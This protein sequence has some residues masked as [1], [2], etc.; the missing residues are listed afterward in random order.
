M[1]SMKILLVEDEDWS[2]E[3]AIEVLTN[4]DPAAEIMVALYRDDALMQ[5]RDNDFDL[6]IC[7]LRLPPIANSA[8]VNEQHGL[9][10]HGLARELCPGT[11]LTFLTGYPVSRDTMDKLSLGD[12]DTLFGLPGEALVR[13]VQKDDMHALETL[14]SRYAGA[15][16][17][18]DSCCTVAGGELLDPLLARA[19]RIYALASGHD[20]AR[21]EFASG[22]SGASVGRVLLE[23]A[24]LP[25]ARVF[26]KVLPSAAARD[27]FDRCNRLVAN[28]I[29][30]GYFAPA[31]AP[32]HSGLRKMSALVSPLASASFRSLFDLARTDVTKA[33]EVISEL[34]R[35]TT[36]WFSSTVEEPVTLEDLRR[37]RIS[38]ERIQ[39][40]VDWDRFRL[41]ESVGVTM[42]MGIV[43]GDLHGENVLVD[44]VGRPVLIDFGDVG[45]GFA[46]TDPVTL[47]LSLIYHKDGPA[48][49][50][51]L[52]ASIN[53][54]D[55]LNVEVCYESS[56]LQPLAIECRAW[57]QE[58]ADLHSIAAFAYAH[59]MRQLKYPDVPHAVAVEVAAACGAF[60]EAPAG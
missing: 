5:I 28:R 53:W 16:Q 44:A 41:F 37:Q 1:G 24:I 55:W 19:V 32:I 15:L 57:A 17:N 34:R 2:V 13:L 43:H 23:S 30:I 38:D 52:G 40:L 14:V 21:V 20:S 48:R 7:D 9:A 31:L 29:P 42:T 8:D 4:A 51:D 46:P 47:E 36:D 58:V 27:E 3:Q 11:P 12:V 22:L 6:I 59:S 39:D 18:L 45:I 26:L 49:D 35:A 50:P 25:P 56:S 33:A 10:V 54:A 60:L